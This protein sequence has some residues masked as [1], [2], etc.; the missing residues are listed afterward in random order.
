LE[1]CTGYRVELLQRL[2]HYCRRQVQFRKPF[3]TV[4]DLLEK[5]LQ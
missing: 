1:R 5:T 2:T 3:S 4:I